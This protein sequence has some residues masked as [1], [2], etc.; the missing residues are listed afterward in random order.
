MAVIITITH[1]KT[2][3]APIWPCFVIMAGNEMG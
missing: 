3:V 2:P 1:D